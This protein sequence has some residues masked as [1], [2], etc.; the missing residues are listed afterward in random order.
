MPALDGDAATLGLTA[1]ASVQVSFKILEK[2]ETRARLGVLVSSHDNHFAVA[3]SLLLKEEN[4]SS[5]GANRILEAFD[6]GNRHLMALNLQTITEILSM[7]RDAVIVAPNSLL[8]ASKDSLKAAP[9]ES[10]QLFD[11]RIAAVTA[12]DASEQSTPFGERS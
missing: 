2:W 4:I 6:T 3:L 12:S 5:L 10:K 8:R 11:G 9:L 7:R 1:P